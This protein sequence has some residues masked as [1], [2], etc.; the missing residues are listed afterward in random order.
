MCGCGEKKP[1]CA[2]SGGIYGIGR[3]DERANSTELLCKLHLP[4]DCLARC[5]AENQ[6]SEITVAIRCDS[7]VSS[8]L[9]RLAQ[10]SMPDRERV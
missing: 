9:A 10:G 5:V 8:K 2:A 6:S 7:S 3:G 1:V 4:D